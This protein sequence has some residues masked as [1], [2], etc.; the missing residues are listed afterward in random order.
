MTTSVDDRITNVDSFAHDG[1]SPKRFQANCVRSH[2]PMHQN[3]F[4]DLPAN[5]L[6]SPPPTCLEKVP[7]AC[8]EHIDEYG[9]EI[10][11][12]GRWI[13][14]PAVHR[15][16]KAIEVIRRLMLEFGMTPSSRAGLRS[17]ARH[18]H[19]CQPTSSH[20]GRTYGDLMLR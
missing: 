16:Q 14:N 8:A 5:L 11:Y 9:A 20:D 1:A 2:R 3:V 7:A 10:K 18:S 19:S 6:R 4:F 17:S 15:R 13:A 12:D